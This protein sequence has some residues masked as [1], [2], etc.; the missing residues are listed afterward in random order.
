MSFMSLFSCHVYRRSGRGGKK[1]AAK[2]KRKADHQPPPQRKSRKKA[3]AALASAVQDVEADDAH[4]QG[5]STFRTY[6]FNDD[7]TYAST[8]AVDA[9]HES[10]GEYDGDRDDD[11]DDDDDVDITLINRET[12]REV[13]I[14]ISRRILNEHYQGDPCKGREDNGEDDDLA[15][16]EKEEIKAAKNLLTTYGGNEREP[17]NVKDD[18]K[19]ANKVVLEIPDLQKFDD[20]TKYNAQQWNRRYEELKSYKEDNG[21]CNV[22]TKSADKRKLGRWVSTQ[23]EMYQLKE[24]G[25]KSPMTQERIDKL[26]QIDFVW[27]ASQLSG[28]KGKGVNEGTWDLWLADLVAYKEEHGNCLVP[29]DYKPNKPLGTWVSGQRQQYRRCQ[30]GKKSKITQER[31]DKLNEIGFVWDAR[32]KRLQSALRKGKQGRW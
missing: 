17:F 23:R 21:H 4:S 5:D 14:Q 1:K 24:K 18:D 10:M 6:R 31:I 11:D 32:S 25:K 28:F 19:A 8:I 29:A 13:V 12:Q 30:E 27:D 15:S 3:G 26:N 7:D 16:I 20:A 2:N 22:S 9:N